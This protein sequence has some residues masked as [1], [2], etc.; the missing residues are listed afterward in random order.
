MKTIRIKLTFQED[1][2][3]EKLVQDCIKEYGETYHFPFEDDTEND[4]DLQELLEKI[5]IEF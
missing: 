1:L 3:L 4:V 5:K 2:L